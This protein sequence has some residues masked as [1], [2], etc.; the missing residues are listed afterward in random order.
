MILYP[1]ETIYALG[2]NAFDQNEL[3]KLYALKGRDEGK[4]VSLL[5]RSIDDI[6]RYAELSPRAKRLAEAFLPGPLTLVL[7]ALEQAPRCSVFRDGTLSF[8]VSSDSIAQKLIE[9]FMNEYNAPLTCTSANI[10][11]FPTLPTPAEI[12]NQFSEAG[13]DVAAIDRCIDDGSRAGIAS[14]VLSV[15]GEEVFIHREGAVSSEAIFAV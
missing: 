8:R 11:D 3:I 14:T 15:I 13:H 12:L 9:E 10:S 1:T 2:V 6:E 5:V 4:P 7:P